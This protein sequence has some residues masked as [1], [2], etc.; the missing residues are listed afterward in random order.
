M[1]RNYFD[2]IRKSIIDD[3]GCTLDLQ[4]VP[5]YA[6][7][8]NTFKDTVKHHIINGIIKWYNFENDVY[9]FEMSSLLNK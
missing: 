7:D 9:N 6:W 2:C 4:W 5:D 1:N 3:R 8:L